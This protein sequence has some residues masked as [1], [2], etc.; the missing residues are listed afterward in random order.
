[1]NVSLA[2]NSIKSGGRLSS[3]VGPLI[4]ESDLGIPVNV[5]DGL[6]QLCSRSPFGGDSEISK[7]EAKDPRRVETL[8]EFVDGRIS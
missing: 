5:E 2:T 6:G 3:A 4:H 1:M 7:A 8:A